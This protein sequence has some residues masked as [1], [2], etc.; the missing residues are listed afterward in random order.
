MTFK[1]RKGGCDTIDFL[2]THKL[3]NHPVRRVQSKPVKLEERNESP[4]RRVRY[5]PRVLKLT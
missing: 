1:K 2:L 5:G 3:K 4:P